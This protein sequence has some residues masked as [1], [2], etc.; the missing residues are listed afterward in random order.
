[1]GERVPPT[2]LARANAW[3]LASNCAGSLS[4]PVLIGLAM[5]HFGNR[6]M[7]ATAAAAVVFAV[8]IGALGGL[9]AWLARAN[10]LD[11]PPV[12]AVSE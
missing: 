1:L 9:R 4:G 6:A 10:L 12:Q 5:D 7:F 8:S 3:Y 2:A 11:L